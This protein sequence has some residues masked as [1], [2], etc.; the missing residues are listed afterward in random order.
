MKDTSS[1][2]IAVIHGPNLHLLGTREPGVYGVTTLDELNALVRER[3]TAAGFT[4][5]TEQHN[6]EGAIIDALTA[7][8]DAY[9]VI[10]NAGAYTHYSY[11]IRDAIAGLEVTTI[12]VC[13]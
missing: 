11:A 3:G 8:R 10:L 9:A 1:R 7:A 6:D 13:I 5:T 12:E 4:V 2:R